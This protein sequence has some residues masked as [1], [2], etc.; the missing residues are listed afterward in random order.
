MGYLLAFRSEKL[1]RSHGIGFTNRVEDGCAYG[2]E[3]V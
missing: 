1:N 2:E 3:P